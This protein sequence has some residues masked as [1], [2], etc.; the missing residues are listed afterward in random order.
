[1]CWSVCRSVGLLVGASPCF[2]DFLRANAHHTHVEGSD[3][4][5]GRVAR[6]GHGQA[7]GDSGRDP[8]DVP[9]DASIPTQPQSSNRWPRINGFE[10]VKP[11]FED[12]GCVG[13]LCGSSS[14]SSS[15]F[16][17]AATAAATAAA[18]DQHIKCCP[19][20]KLNRRT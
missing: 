13:I 1:M 18:A 19:K 20:R 6:R 11:I 17:V 12:C 10:H 7:S 5:R 2:T 4:A 8:A 15:L 14:S 9:G 16:W 3:G